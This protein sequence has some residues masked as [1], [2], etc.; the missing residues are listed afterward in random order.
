MPM[1]RYIGISVAS[2]KTKNS[3]ASSAVNTPIISPE[4]MRKAPMY[5][6]TRYSITSQPAI[7]TMT[8]MKAVSNTNQREM[9][10]TPR[11]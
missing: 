6:L 11:W 3:I 7:T 10:S 4:R 9:P 2:K 5:W 8:V 1:I